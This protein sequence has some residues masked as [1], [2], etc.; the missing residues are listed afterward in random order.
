M[1]IRMSRGV[2]YLGRGS[3]LSDA[4]KEML[5]DTGGEPLQLQ[6]TELPFMGVSQAHTS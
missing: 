1:L 4:L 6:H 2:T 5:K 3:A